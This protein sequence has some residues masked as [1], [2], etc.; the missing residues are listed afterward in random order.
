HPYSAYDRPRN[1]HDSRSQHAERPS[2]ER[3]SDRRG[4]GA[5]PDPALARTRQRAGP[6]G[7]PYAWVWRLTSSSPQGTPS[8]SEQRHHGTQAQARGNPE[9]QG[10]ADDQSV[11]VGARSGVQYSDRARAT[12]RYEPISDCARLSERRL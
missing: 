2:V 9:R 8:A 6:F 3:T 7:D 4:R 10:D 12:V 5:P 1:A 11:V